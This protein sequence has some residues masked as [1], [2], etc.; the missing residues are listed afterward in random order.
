MTAITT[1]ILKQVVGAPSRV[2]Y[3]DLIRSRYALTHGAE[4]RQFMPNLLGCIGRDGQPMAV[5]GYQS[6]AAGPLFLEQY[7][8]SPIEQILGSRGD[9]GGAAVRLDR[10]RIVEVGNFASRDRAA[11]LE[12][13]RHLPRLRA[14]EGFAWLVFTGTPRVCALVA[15]F[16]A[17]LLD[18]GRADPAR[19]QSGAARWGRY[20]ESAPRIMAGWLGH[21]AQVAA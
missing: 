7:L 15:G 2:E 20:Y 1:R 5:L 6:A 19:L 4:L 8:D 18:L 14:R 10:Q 3:E 17:P 21:C 11:T 13:L 9:V 12:L 16:G